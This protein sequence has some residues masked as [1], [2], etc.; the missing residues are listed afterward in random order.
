LP[1]S[2]AEPAADGARRYELKITATGVVRDAAGN[3]V[4][5]EPVEATAI[6]TEAEIL[7]HLERTPK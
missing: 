1:Y 6:L 7:A 2:Q 3:V 5:Q 4:S